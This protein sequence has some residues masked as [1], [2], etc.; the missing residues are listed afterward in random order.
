MSRIRSTA[1]SSSLFTIS[2][3]NV[4][5]IYSKFIHA[6][7]Q[8]DTKIIQLYLDAYPELICQ[9]DVNYDT[10]LHIALQ[11]SNNKI[12]KL[13]LIYLKKY[14]DKLKISYFFSLLKGNAQHETPLHIAAKHQGYTTFKSLID[15]LDNHAF[16]AAKKLTIKNLL[17]LHYLAFN[18]KS[19]KADRIYQTL[20]IYTISHHQLKKIDEPILLQ[21][22]LDENKHWVN[23]H[24]ILKKNLILAYL[25]ACHVRNHIHLSSTHPDCNHLPSI[26]VKAIWGYCDAVRYTYTEKNNALTVKDLTCPDAI[27]L[28]QLDTIVNMIKEYKAGKCL[29]YSYFM[30]DTLIKMG[31]QT[32]VEVYEI[33]KGN[34]VFIVIGRNEDSHAYDHTTWGENAV[35]VDAWGGDIYPA[36]RIR[37]KLKTYIYYK[38]FS[39]EKIVEDTARIIVPFDPMVHSL[40]PKVESI[41]MLS[42]SFFENNKEHYDHDFSRDEIKTI[43]KSLSVLNEQQENEIKKQ[44]HS[45]IKNPFKWFFNKKKNDVSFEISAQLKNQLT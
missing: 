33:V 7:K 5:I 45:K 20:K 37:E 22:I 31:I 15:A 3:D 14:C 17:P 10:P 21:P 41:N 26:E 36:C 38:K 42:R 18:V 25:A 1:P 8:K 12:V 4:S 13:L 24:S 19:E 6:I 34:H 32:S 39:P 2:K 11:Y 23:D 29:E 35:V 27:P 43:K 16:F 30:L 44:S 9:D 28:L 40:R